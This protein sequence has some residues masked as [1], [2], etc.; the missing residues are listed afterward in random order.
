M[1]QPDYALAPVLAVW[2]SKMA[3]FI[4]DD[5]PTGV[6]VGVLQHEVWQG[7]WVKY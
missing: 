7:V 4:K 2:L 3:S 1:C 5:L 6:Q